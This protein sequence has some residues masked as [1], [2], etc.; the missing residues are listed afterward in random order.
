M[1]RQEG[2]VDRRVAVTGVGAVSGLGW[3]VAPFQ[4]GLRAGRTALSG[5]DRFDHTEH[6]THLAAQVPPPPPGAAEDPDWRRLSWCDRF[7]L[8]AAGEALAQAGLAAAPA[9]GLAA[10]LV[11]GTDPATVG[12]YFGSSTGGMFEAEQYYA[13]QADRLARRAAPSSEPDAGRSAAGA[14]IGSIFARL[15]SHPVSSPGDA[16]ARRLGVC[17]PVQTW[18]TACSSAS[19]ALAAAL[20]ALRSG[21]VEVAIAGGADSLCQLTYAGF[22]ALRSVAERPCRP[23]QT[24]RDGM[25]IGEGA[26]VLVLEPL[27]RALARGARPLALLAGAGTSCDAHHMT[28]PDPT[29]AGPATAVAAALADA[30]VAPAAIAFVDVHGT[31]TPLNDAAEWR[32]LDRIFGDRLASLPL[33]ATKALV[34][35]LLGSA[36]ALEAVA[37]VLCLRAGEVHPVPADGP[38]DPGLPAV[39][40][41]GRPLPLPA[42]EEERAALSTNLAFGGS[43]AALVFCEWRGGGT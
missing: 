10:P 30:G 8:A 23:F 34:G 1:Q 6:R 2:P 3:G 18:S 27:A 4:E 31:G 5:F 43:N 21:E 29:G 9:R 28:A 13:D 14:S 26:A 19:L 38:A 20:D 35:H 11:V 7:A 37:T 41:Q 32:A 24:D 39:L 16:V 25:S 40:V 33:A 17:G 22:N 12:V 36:G 15:A 42:T